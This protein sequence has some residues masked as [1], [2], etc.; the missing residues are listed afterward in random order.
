MTRVAIFTDND[1][2]KVNGVT[3]TLNAVLRHAPEDVKPCVFTLS[4]LGVREPDYVALIS[5]GAGI[6]YYREMRLY[7]PRVGALGREVRA[8]GASVVHLTTP[9]PVGLAARRIA[10]RLGL[11]LVGSFHTHLAE[12][13]AALTGSETL[14]RAVNAYMRWLYAPCGQVLVPSAATASLLAAAGWPADR[15]A[16]WTRGVDAST[17]TPAR[18]SAELREQ[19]RVSDRRPA[20]LYAGR[21]SR[22][23]GLALLPQIESCLYRM[24]VPF[25]LIIVGDGPYRRELQAACPDAVFMG[26]LGRDA[27]ADAMAS[28]DAFLFPS[29]TDSLGNVVL[30]A[31]ASGLPV[32]VSDQ[33][34]PRENME[35]W[36]TGHVS[37]AGDARDFAWRAASLLQNTAVRQGMSAS[38]RAYAEQRSWASALKPLYEMWRAGARTAPTP[39]A[40]ALSLSERLS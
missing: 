11:P 8:F 10:R 4:D 35:P 15:L 26:T 24:R 17:F 31:Q 12:Y 28:A 2:G 9:G 16:L 39:A 36:A 6:P 20:L 19:W 22:E 7:A 14:G 3:T 18:R 13:A 34:G 27:V 37:A 1:F 40:R 38:A 21:V 33:G 5:R 30:E 32:I 29:A 25:R 23:K